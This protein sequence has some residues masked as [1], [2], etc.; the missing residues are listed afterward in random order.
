[1]QALR[2]TKVGLLSQEE[3]AGTSRVLLLSPSRGL[4][5]GIERYLETLSLIQKSQDDLAGEPPRI[6]I[7]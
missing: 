6:V 2:H 5:G 7:R 1:V 4:G 3:L